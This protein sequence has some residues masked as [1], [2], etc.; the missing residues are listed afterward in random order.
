[1]LCARRLNSGMPYH[2]SPSG[3]NCRLASQ[4]KLSLVLIR[5]KRTILMMK[6]LGEIRHCFFPPLSLA[7]LARN[8]ATGVAAAVVINAAAASKMRIQVVRCMATES[9]ESQHDQL[10]AVKTNLC[11]SGRV[12]RTR[13][14][15]RA[16]VEL[17]IRGLPAA[18]ILQ[19]GNTEGTASLFGVPERSRR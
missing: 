7:S 18:C 11:D 13:E 8:A 2:T 9:R 15:S 12:R 14:S 3:G 17:K 4:L 19:A 10:R 1:M 6:T 5:A 16:G